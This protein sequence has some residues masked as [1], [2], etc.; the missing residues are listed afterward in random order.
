LY[1]D[2][3][4]IY[5]RPVDG[6]IELRHA[7][8]DEAATRDLVGAATSVLRDA[9]ATYDDVNLIHLSTTVFDINMA[10]LVKTV[11]VYALGEADDQVPS[12]AH[13]ALMRPLRERLLTFGDEVEAGHA[14][15]LGDYEPERYFVE[16]SEAADKMPDNNRI[17]WPWPN[18]DPTD[19]VHQDAHTRTRIMSPAELE[20]VL[21]FAGG[22]HLTAIAVD[23]SRYVIH[24]TPLLP[25]QD[26]AYR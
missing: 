2:G 9:K 8:L 21:P 5:T 26:L 22:Q 11:S 1:S 14:S 24:V 19:F 15:D 13:R 16:L 18:L 4:V 20:E 10:D 17:D 25:D 6:G 7:Q 12:A 3:H 23:G